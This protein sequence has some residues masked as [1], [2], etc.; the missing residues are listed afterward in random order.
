MGLATG[1]KIRL[2]LA[3]QSLKQLSEKHKGGFTSILFREDFKTYTYI[4]SQFIKTS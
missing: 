2:S 4:K 3:A 1:L